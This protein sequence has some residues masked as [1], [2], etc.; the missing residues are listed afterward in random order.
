MKKIK[1]TSRVALGIGFFAAFFTAQGIPILAIPYYQMTLGVDPF[2]LSVIM[3]LPLLLG[4]SIGPVVGHLSDNCRSKYGRRRPFIFMASWCV[5]LCYGLIWMVPASWSER[6]QLIYFAVTATFFYVAVAFY[7]VPLNGMA[8]ELSDDYHQRT[9]IM[10][11]TAYFLKAGALLYQWVFPLAQLTIFGGVYLGI[12]YVGWGLA[13]IVFGLFGTLPAL[14]ISESKSIAGRQYP[15]LGFKAGLRTVLRNRSMLLLLGITI[16]QLGGAAYAAMMDYYLLV[17][18]VYAGDISQGAIWKGVLSTSYA[19]ISILY[20]PVITRI[21]FRVGKANTLKLIYLLNAV[22][23]LAKWF[24]F[25]P[26]ARWSIMLDA[27]LCSAIWTAMVVLVPSMIADAS[28]QNNSQQTNSP[29]GVY[30]SV[31][32]A[33]AGYSGVLALLVCGL[34]LN[35]IGFD[36]QLKGNQLDVTL[37]SMRLILSGGTLLFSLVALALLQYWQ[38]DRQKI[39]SA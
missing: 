29:A 16:L 12:R 14:L 7:T 20:V 26:G 13:F 6:E 2:L 27:L 4:N 11:F 10:G 18:Y 22:G 3:T 23:G 9:A 34:S 28:Q 31:H 1:L 38:I 32:G 36:A 17:Y 15:S 25:V 24:I 8:Y 21:S 19:T 33:V 37:H 35:I 30:A 5:C 39:I